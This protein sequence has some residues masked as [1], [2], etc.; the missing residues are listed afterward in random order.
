MP[1][2]IIKTMDQKIQFIADW[3]L[4][5]FSLTDL[6]QK[7]GISRPTGYKLLERYEQ[8]GIEGLKEQ[9]RAPKNCPHRTPKEILN[10]I[11][12]E[13]LKNRKRGPRKI[14][15]QLNRQ[16]PELNLP[17]VSTVSY[18]LKKEGLVEKRKKRLHVPAYT[19]PFSNCQSPNDVWSI[20]YKGQFYMKNGHVCYP[21]TVSDNCSRFLLG[22]K[23]LAGPRYN[24]TRRYLESIFH[25]YGLPDAIRN[26]NGTPFASKCIGGLSRL[27]IWFIQQNIIPERIEKGCPQENG[28]HERMHRTLK[29]DVLDQKAKN[30]KEQQ[31]I[32]D[33]FRHD[34]NNYRPH[35]ALNDQVPSDYYKKSNRPY[36]EHPHPPEYGYEYKVRRVRQSG[37]IKL[38]GR[39][40][41]ITELLAGQPVGLKEIADG[42]WQLQYSFYVLGSVDL[43]KNKIIR[44]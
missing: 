19:Q 21:L 14:R 41:Y 4:Q 34:Y 10:L 36:I 1:W 7:Y 15:A 33:M 2:K 23:A 44:N 20:D 42:I 35:E 40:F 5:N 26:D 29:N 6:C 37:D 11:F 8:L 28:R 27:S 12:Q 9:S 43:R 17:A 18:W 13:K 32:F 30:Y 39:M 24:P 38:M 25:E 16:Y 3:Q 22:C 31:K